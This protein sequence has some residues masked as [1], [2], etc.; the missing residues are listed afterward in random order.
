M[1]QLH[2]HGRKAKKSVGTSSDKKLGE[3]YAARQVL[4]DRSLLNTIIRILLAT[5][6]LGDRPEK[7]Q[8]KFILGILGAAL[9]R[10]SLHGASKTFKNSLSGTRLREIAET[11]EFRKLRFACHKAL[12]SGIKTI[13]DGRCVDLALSIRLFSIYDDHKSISSSIGFC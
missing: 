4:S 5:L 1:P 2:R 11:L 8:K 13:L 6:P 3:R 12:Q 10:S 9:N 7:Q